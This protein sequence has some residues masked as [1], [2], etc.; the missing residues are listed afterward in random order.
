MPV[1]R[2]P[3]VGEDEDLIVVQISVHEHVAQG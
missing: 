1:I 3:P 2:I